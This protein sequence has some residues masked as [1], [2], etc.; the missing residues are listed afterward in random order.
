MTH[1]V[2]SAGMK[3]QTDDKATRDQQGYG[4]FT[5]A[6]TPDWAYGERPRSPDSQWQ[7]LISAVETGMTRSMN[8]DDEAANPAAPP[9]PRTPQRCRKRQ[10]NEDSSDEEPETE[11]T[12][13]IKRILRTLSSSSEVKGCT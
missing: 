6:N 13:T 10:D 9:G 8:E 2:G 1:I 3:Q 5:H 12:P 7:G 4:F 11:K